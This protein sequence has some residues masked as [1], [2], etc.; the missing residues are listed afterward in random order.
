MRNGTGAV[1]SPVAVVVAASSRRPQ[2]PTVDE[3]VVGKCRRRTA[4]RSSSRAG[5]GPRPG[6]TVL[7]RVT[8]DDDDDDDDK[9]CGL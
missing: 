6:V 1:S 2:A 5:S 9:E 3:A 8:A 4:V 7:L